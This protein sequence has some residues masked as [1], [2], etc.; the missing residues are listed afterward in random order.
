MK[1]AID[2]IKVREDVDVK[3]SRSYAHA[4][5]DF[6]CIFLKINFYDIGQVLSAPV[7]YTLIFHRTV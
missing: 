5:F 3:K 2:S 1:V 4:N 7:T 6:E